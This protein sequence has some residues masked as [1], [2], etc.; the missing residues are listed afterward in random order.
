MTFKTRIKLK[1]SGTSR[2][3]LSFLDMFVPEQELSWEI[4]CLDMVRVSHHYFSFG[5]H[6]DHCEILQQFTANSSS[7]NNEGFQWLDLINTFFSYNNL[8]TS[9]IFRALDGQL[10]KLVGFF[11]DFLNHF[12]EM[13]GP[14]LLDRHVFI[15]DSFDDFLSNN[16]SKVSSNGRQLSFSHIA[17]VIGK[18]QCIFDLFLALVHLRDHFFN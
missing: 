11:R 17:K 9:E 12:I 3:W 1:K 4:G 15:G 16:A 10:F 7:P 5:S 13:E 8:E 18:F 14:E 6:I 2:S